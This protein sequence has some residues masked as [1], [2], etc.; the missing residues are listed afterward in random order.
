VPPKR[1]SSQRRLHLLTMRQ[2]EELLFGPRFRTTRDGDEFRSSFA[3]E[4]ERRQAWQF[5]GP[6]LVE[7]AAEWCPRMPMRQPWGWWMYE[8]TPVRLGWLEQEHP[9]VHRRLL[10]A[11]ERTTFRGD[12]LARPSV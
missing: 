2:E 3:S 8:S 10:E 6:D 11:E 5:R 7:R 1:R 12:E 4:R 9:D